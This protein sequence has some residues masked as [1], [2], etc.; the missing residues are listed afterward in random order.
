MEPVMEPLESPFDIRDLFWRLRRYAWLIALPVIFCLCGAAIYCKFTPPTYSSQIVISVD[1]SGQ[2]TAPAVDPL[3]EAVMERP[4]PR[5]RVTLVDSKIHSRAFLSTLVERLGMNRDPGVILRATE[6]S[7]R[8]KGITPE[9]YAMRMCTT[10]IGSKISVMPGRA[11]LIQISAVDTDPQAA[12]QLADMIGQVLLEE[13]RESTAERVQARGDFSSDQI[14]VYEDRVRKAEEALKD[15]Q[16]ARL[17]SGYSLGT[18]TK[19]NL[20]SARNLQRSTEDAMEQIS[21]R[22]Q[23]ARND[24]KTTQGDT[25]IPELKNGSVNEAINRL[26]DLETNYGLALLR[27]GPENRAEGDAMQARV[28]AARQSLF[29]EFGD[30]ARSLPGGLGPEARAA[31]AGIAFDRA[32][33]SSLVSRRD[34]IASEIEGYLKVAEG[35]PREELELQRLRQDVQSNSDFLATLRREA[36][37]S[38]LSEAL[39]SSSLGPKLEIVEPPLLPYEP[40]GPQKR[41][42]F[43]IAALLGVLMGAGLVFAAERFVQ[44]LRTLEQAET[45][46]GHRVLGTIP[47][48]EGWSPPGSFLQNNWAALAI[49]L[50]LLATGLVFALHSRPQ[51]RQTRASSA[52]ELPH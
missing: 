8:W 30:V 5:D 52:L 40:I 47:R 1:G 15:F 48:I 33:L 45:E 29:A 11:A 14:A 3:V 37:S 49:L 13:S 26:E 2:Q 25:P 39:A 23:S 19:D 43:G 17:R 42:V 9:D 16:E 31:A 41:K 38:H 21:A 35:A 34:R 4:N 44:V 46:Y 20:T 50:V 51:D 28:A 27:Q 36:T 22:I 18:I 7:R 12:R 24:W 32:V 10:I 6:A